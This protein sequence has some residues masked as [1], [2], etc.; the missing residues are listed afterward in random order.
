MNMAI[1]VRTK[2]PQ[3][4]I[5]QIVGTEHVVSASL[6]EHDGEITA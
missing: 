5:R 4:L 6:L 3:A 1:E 2:E